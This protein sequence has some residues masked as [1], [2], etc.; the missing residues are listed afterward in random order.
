VRS[1]GPLVGCGKK[2]SRSVVA[3]SPWGFFNTPN[4]TEYV[5]AET[6]DD[7]LLSAKPSTSTLVFFSIPPLFAE[8]LRG[9]EGVSVS[10]T[11][12]YLIAPISDTDDA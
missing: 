9:R 1:T 4:V 10:L 7:F 12:A 8:F 2:W 5:D 11:H 3:F 6:W